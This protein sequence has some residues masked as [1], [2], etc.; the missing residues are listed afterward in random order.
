MVILHALGQCLIRTGV[1]AIG[2]RAELGF[3][4]ATRLI[5]DRGRRLTR[6]YLTALFWPDA[7]EAKAAHSLSEAL[8]R[9]RARGVP[10]ESDASHAVWVARESAMLDVERIPEIAPAELAKCDFTVLPGFEPTGSPELVDWA[11]D[12]RH[13]LRVLT[14]RNIKSVIA[15]AESAG[16]WTNALTLAERVLDLDPEDPDA[17][18]AMSRA[19]DTIRARRRAQ[20][21][22]P[23]D[24]DTRRA[25]TSGMA[26]TIRESAPTLTRCTL[27][28]LPTPQSEGALIGRDDELRVLREAWELARRGRGQRVWVHG[29]SGIG[30]TR[31]TQHFFRTAR[32]TGGVVAEVACDPSDAR[33]PLSTFM[34]LVPRLRMLPGAAGSSPELRPY[35]DRL[36]EY[37]GGNTQWPDASEATYGL[38]CIERAIEELIDAIA[39]EQPLL[40]VVDNAQWIDDDSSRLLEVIALAASARPVL[41]LAIACGPPPYQLSGSCM[42]IVPLAVGPLSDEAARALIL[43]RIGDTE[44]AP[45]EALLE[46][47]VNAGEG[48]PLRLEELVNHWRTGGPPFELPATL[49]ALLKARV[50][51]LAP[52]ERRLL[53]VVALL[54]QQATLARVERVA[55]LDRTFLLDHVERLGAAG[56]LVTD[57]R[58]RGDEDTSSAMVHLAC[59]HDALAR[60][61]IEDLSPPALAL[62]HR[63][64]ASALDADGSRSADVLWDRVTHWSAS[65]E[66]P[67]VV[68]TTVSCAR[69]LAAVG[70]ADAAAAACRQLLREPLPP[71]ARRQALNAL[72]HSLHL[73]WKWAELGE[74]VAQ[75]RE[76]EGCTHAHDDVELCLLDAQWQL[77]DN[78]ESTLQAAVACASAA[79]AS[80]AHRVRGAA[81]ALKLATNSGQL[82]VLRDVF[83]HV[84]GVLNEPD[85]DPGDRICVEMM[86][87]AVGGSLPLAAQ[88]ARALIRVSAR[89]PE[90]SRLRAL[91]NAAAALARA[92]SLFEALDLCDTAAHDAAR[93]GLTPLAMAACHRAANIC[94]D[95]G[96]LDFAVS[97]VDRLA[98]HVVPGDVARQKAVLLAAARL[99][100]HAGRLDAA[101]SSLRHEGVPIWQNT[102]PAFEATSL[103][104]AIAIAARSK[105]DVAEVRT[106][107]ARVLPLHRRL[108]A[109][110]AHD[111]LA[112]AIAS[113]Y[114][115]V[116]ET[117][118]AAKLLRTYLTK[119][120]REGVPVSE[121]FTAMVALR[122]DDEEYLMGRLPAAVSEAPACATARCGRRA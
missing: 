42:P 12:F 36:T 96:E 79:D 107:L 120:R 109:M 75:L 54:G 3:A 101:E 60:A 17:L 27:P 10:I 22:T 90:P 62:L 31:L 77:Q 34:R 91:A 93:R 5:A 112:F 52:G 53:Q 87:H 71:S 19:A 50:A 29:G 2:P 44:V 63:E 113:G 16:D 108:Q 121:R 65:N 100:Y 92:G 55:A 38:T 81:T 74:A 110:G 76:M 85:V 46:W 59:R 26:S 103:A 83:E 116:G 67:D 97:W 72:A 30:K 25:S 4:L 99:H 58:A 24:S 114:E 15:R 68:R 18:T 61:A 70:L 45:D 69:H 23:A 111:F 6:R 89:M 48:N 84:A 106:M 98:A 43:E 105:R 57:N 78:W 66:L 119:H 9:L 115:Y 95:A 88:Y 80:P 122:L 11:D 41:V 14:V 1:A 51:A 13:Q 118:Q 64:I 40:L 102:A 21:Q 28:S 8:H 20:S 104:T 33:R 7:D 82:T 86:Y 37:D 49:T 39:D 47:I 56:L 117:S 35:L 32:R 73:G 94:L